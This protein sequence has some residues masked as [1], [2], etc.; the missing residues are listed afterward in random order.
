[1][2]KKD[3]INKRK[4][5]MITDR[6]EL[7]KLFDPEGGVGRAVEGGRMGKR[8]GELSTKCVSKRRRH[9]RVNFPARQPKR[10]GKKKKKGKG[11]YVETEWGWGTQGQK[12]APVVR[13]RGARRRDRTRKT[14]DSGYNLIIL[15]LSKKKKNGGARS[16]FFSRPRSGGTR[17]GRVVGCEMLKAMSMGAARGE[18]KEHENPWISGELESGGWGR[19]EKKK[20]M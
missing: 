16:H 1:M 5:E 18:K 2:L 10:V 14:Y 15:D 11:I 19:R 17:A 3:R 6:V 12:L 9:K 7:M 8:G 13:K 4:V 20:R